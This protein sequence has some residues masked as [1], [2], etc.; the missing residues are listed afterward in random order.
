MKNP[1]IG[2][3]SEGARAAKDCCFTAD[4]RWFR[5][6]TA[7]IIVEQGRVLFVGSPGA[8][9]LYSVGGG[10]HMGETS[11]D[12]VRREVYEET[13]VHYE[14][15]RLAVVSENFFRGNFSGTW[16]MHCQCL[17]LY[18]I[19]KPQGKCAEGPG[20]PENGETLHW[21][22]IEELKDANIKPEFLRT[23]LPEILESRSTM[24]IVVPEE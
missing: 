16:G 9:F 15:D 6:R 14:I 19:M 18:Y 20:V 8:E 23:R 3:E 24:H 13:G 12:C 17:E 11:E 1:V 5:Y 7:A 4:D 22:P 10:V 21:V 2:T